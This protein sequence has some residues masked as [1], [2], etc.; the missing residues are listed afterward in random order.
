MMWEIR[1]AHILDLR[2]RLKEKT[3]LNTVNK[4][5][6]TVKTV[7]SEAYFRQE[8]EIDPGSRIGNIQHAKQERGILSLEELGFLFKEI[9]GPWGDLQAYCVFN[10][11]VKTGMRCGE[12]LALTWDAIDFQADTIDIRQAWK[13]QHNRGLPKSNKK[14]KIPVVRSVLDPLLQLQEESVRIATTDLVFCYE[15]GLRLGVTWWKNRFTKAMIKAEE[16]EKACTDWK[17]RNITPHSLRHSLNSHLLNSG[18]DPIKVRAYMGWSDN[19]VQ[20]ILTAVQAGYTHWP[21]DMLRDLL[22]SID[23]LFDVNG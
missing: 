1:R 5:I 21:P 18:C 3:G 19:I 17:D 7:L 12:V 11:A 20:P 23:A 16:S 9:P 10:T 8:I 14:R 4:V 13:D 6:A 2:N 22:P 15:D